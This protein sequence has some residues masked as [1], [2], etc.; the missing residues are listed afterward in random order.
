[1]TLQINGSIKSSSLFLERV[2]EEVFDDTGIKI[3]IIHLHGLEEEFLALFGS[4]QFCFW[5]NFRTEMHNFFQIQTILLHL[6]L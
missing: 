5:V 3:T 6:Y 2:I 1:M 4:F